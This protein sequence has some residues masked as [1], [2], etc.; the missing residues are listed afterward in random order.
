[1][2]IKHLDFEDTY[3]TQ[4]GALNALAT[5]WRQAAPVVCQPCTGNCKQGDACPHRTRPQPA[6]AATS[7]GHTEPRSTWLPAVN[8]F[9]IVA[10]FCIAAAFAILKANKP[11]V[12]VALCVLLPLVVVSAVALLARWKVGA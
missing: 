1:M 3:P 11:A 12:I 5:L 2:R 9:L 4:P 10:A 6:E 7:V 8:V